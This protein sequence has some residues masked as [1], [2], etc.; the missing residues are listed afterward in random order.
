MPVFFYVSFVPVLLGLGLAGV[1]IYWDHRRD[2]A[3]IEKGL[4]LPV[5]RAQSFLAWG[6][7]TTGGGTG[8]FAGAFWT[9]MPEVEMVGLRRDRARGPLGDDADAGGLSVSGEAVTRPR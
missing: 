6:L 3:L 9:G 1:I 7:V 2:R 4:Y 5:T 8:I